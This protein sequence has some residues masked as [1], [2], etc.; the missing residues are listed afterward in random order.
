M[1]DNYTSESENWKFLPEYGRKNPFALPEG[2]FKNLPDRLIN[3]IE[4]NDELQQF[5]LLPLISKQTAFSV[6]EDYFNS[7]ENSLEY[8]FELSSLKELDKIKGALNEKNKEVYFEILDKKL[9]GKIEIAEELEEF[10]VLASVEKR[11]NYIVNPDYFETVA[12]RI[13][14]KKYSEI[15][16]P[17]VMERLIQFIFKPQVVLAY[18]VIFILAIGLT[19][20]YNNPD[21]VVSEDCKTLACLEKNELL[22]EQNMS[23]FDEDNLYEEVDVNILDKQLSTEANSDKDSVINKTIADSIKQ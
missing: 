4:V 8:Q 5:S 1:S 14:E 2:Y 18:S 7:K 16:R 20:D 3:K 15:N 22:N 23:D 9:A 11:N 12:D 6:P 21:S 13:K 19:L 10:K 17:S